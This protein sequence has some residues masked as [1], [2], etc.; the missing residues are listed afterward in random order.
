M[1]T[2]SKKIY[3]FLLHGD[4]QKP[5]NAGTPTAG[6]VWCI[7]NRELVASNLTTARLRLY[8]ADFEGTIKAGSMA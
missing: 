1:K 5:R 3:Y 4:A 6:A 2:L 8:L 7:Y